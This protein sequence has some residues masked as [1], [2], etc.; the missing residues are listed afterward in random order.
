MSAIYSAA[1]TLTVTK[2]GEG[3]V[4]GEGIDCGTDCNQ[5]YSPGTQI[6]LTA[7]PAKDYTFTQWSGACSGTNP[8]C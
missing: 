2:T 1:H 3:V 5:E 4:S 6:T 7:T 8:I